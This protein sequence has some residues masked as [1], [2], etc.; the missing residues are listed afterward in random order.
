MKKILLIVAIAAASLTA[1]AQT[2]V[3]GSVGFW[4][5][6]DKTLLT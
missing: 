4:R 2:Y 1:S 5:N 6:S 3:G